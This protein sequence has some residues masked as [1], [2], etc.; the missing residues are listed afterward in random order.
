MSSL[1]QVPT[2]QGGR[3]GE[4][5]LPKRL[6][7]SPGHKHNTYM[8]EHH[9]CHSLHSSWLESSNNVTAL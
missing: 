3:P 9:T 8:R 2:E 1:L 6:Q 7:P 4:G 5:I